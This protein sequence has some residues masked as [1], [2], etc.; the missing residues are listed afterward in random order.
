[1]KQNKHGEPWI[2]DQSTRLSSIFVMGISG[3]I[4]RFTSIREADRAVL[5][6]NAC[7]GMSNE[8]VEALPKIL[9]LIAQ[10]DAGQEACNKIIKRYNIIEARLDKAMRLLEKYNTKSEDYG[11]N[12]IDTEYYNFRASMK[13]ARS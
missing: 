6:V 5:C 8:E 2:R 13:E 4:A 10:Y 12:D 11:G 9:H 7:E 3:D 1:M